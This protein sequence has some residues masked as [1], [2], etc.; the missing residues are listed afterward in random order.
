MLEIDYITLLIGIVIG[1]AITV[2][3]MRNFIPKRVGCLHIKKGSDPGHYIWD[4]DISEEHIKDVLP[5][6]RISLDVDINDNPY[7]R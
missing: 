1:S 3:I 2:I 6:M 4:F 5:G 7:S